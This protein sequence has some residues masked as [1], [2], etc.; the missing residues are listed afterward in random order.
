MNN[1]RNGRKSNVCSRW[2]LSAF[3]LLGT[4]GLVPTLAWTQVTSGSL[5]GLV[6]DPTGAVVPEA[7]VILTDTNKGYDYQ[8]TTDSVGRY[9]ITNLLPSTYAISVE[10]SGFKTYKREGI[11]LDV[12]TRSSVD[13]RLELGATTQAV[14]V[15]AAAPLLSTQD[16]VTGQEVDRALINDL[17]LVGRAIFDLAFLAPGVIQAPGATFGPQNNGNNFVSNGGRNATA[18]VLIDGVAA[19]T[20]EPNTGINTVLYTPSVDAVQEFKIMQ[21]NYT[22]EEGFTGNTY[23]NMVLRSG[24]N[25]YH[26][27]VYEFLRNEKLDANNWFNGG[28]IPPLRRN[29]YGAT[30]G[31]PIKK[32]KTFFFVYWEGTREHAGSTHNAGVPSALEKQGDFGELC[33]KF[34]ATGSCLDR[35]KD[36]N[37]LH[38]LW[39]PYS[40]TYV[41]GTGRVLQTFIPF[42]NLATFQSAGNPKL[43]GT[44]YQLAAAPGNLIDPVALKMIQYYPAPNVN[45]GTASYDP[46]NN[47]S[48]SGINVNTNDQFDVRI[49]QRF[50][51]RTAFNARF[52]YAQGTYHGMN[53]F[54]NALDPCTQGPG[55]G[56]SRSIALSLNHT[57]SPSTLLNVSV[58]FTRGLS[59]TKGIAKDYPSFDP[60]K[61]L[62]LP[63]YITS[64]GTAASPVVYIGGGYAQASGEALGAQAWSVYKNGNQVYHLLATLTH[65]KGRHEIKL[66]GEWR[67]NQMN[68]YQV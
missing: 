41:A 55:V 65:M 33:Q 1:Q 49:D 61:D 39:D 45:V 56:G 36:G 22:A 5:T 26:G 50:T 54:G 67:E 60:V 38:Q 6:T 52:S 16:A 11:V 24:T 34:D 66:G 48:G 57:F 53:C 12:G 25:Q 40:G 35:D 23:V 18:E 3:V 37:Q 46:Y 20:Y 51:D 21:N 59:D 64:S 28:K 58:G 15:T 7:K 9:V 47:W 29:Q 30:F 31:G 4:V 10:A 32:D 2:L 63:S 14:E 8:A 42:N 17:P 19:T 13:V 68:W 44:P 27:G 62:G 43:N